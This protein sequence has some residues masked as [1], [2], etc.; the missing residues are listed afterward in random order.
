LA[1]AARAAGLDLM[2]GNMCGTSLGMAPAFVVAQQARW[3]DLDG[4]LLFSRDRVPAI[5]FKA[6]C[7][8][9]PPSE[10]WG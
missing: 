10:L 2:V 7:A 1:E 3:A 8:L 5:R 6:G 4:P 9:P